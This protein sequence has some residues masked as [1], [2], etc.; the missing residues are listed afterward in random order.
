MGVN[1]L[2]EN[3]KDIKAPDSIM[4]YI[5]I[6]NWF[7]EYKSS[8]ETAL[9]PL[10]NRAFWSIEGPTEA[11]CIPLYIDRQRGITGCKGP[12]PNDFCGNGRGTC[13]LYVWHEP[14]RHWRGHPERLPVPHNPYYIVGAVLG[15][16]NCVRHQGEGFR[17]QFA[18]P[19]A[20]LRLKRDFLRSHLPANLPR[21][22]ELAARHERNV[23][24]VA[25]SLGAAIVESV[26]EL[27]EFAYSHPK[28]VRWWDEKKDK[29][30]DRKE[31]GHGG[32][33]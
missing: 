28:G 14:P 11:R 23:E 7:H 31:R 3:L 6:R 13:G 25:K 8:P 16:G 27:T 22:H 9:R 21:Y 17:C 2:M 10:N 18:K 4:R 19:I 30:V 5:G 29:P 20:F 12:S 1:E 24:A 33:I 32:Y 26:E 15:W